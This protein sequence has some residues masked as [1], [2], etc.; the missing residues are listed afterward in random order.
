M[1]G[2]H[3]TLCNVRHAVTPDTTSLIII[4]HPTAPHLPPG[5]PHALPGVLGQVGQDGR[6]GR[7]QAA[8]DV[9]LEE[10][11]GGEG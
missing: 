4:T 9:V 6:H 3:H 11:R 8:R 10:W 2:E 1:W 5:Q 7:Q